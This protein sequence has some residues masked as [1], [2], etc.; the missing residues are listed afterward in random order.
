MRPTNMTQGLR[1]VQSPAQALSDGFCVTAKSN[2]PRG[3]A[4]P[5]FTTSTQWYRVP[6]VDH[7]NL[8]ELETEASSADTGPLWETCG[9][10]DPTLEGPHLQ[11]PVVKTATHQGHCDTWE[12]LAGHTQSS[13][14]EAVGLTGWRGGYTLWCPGG[15]PGECP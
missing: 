12:H 3:K 11:S 2:H 1:P 8:S 5:H 4:V 15:R 10:P 14:E 13:L 6:S 7:E 9:H